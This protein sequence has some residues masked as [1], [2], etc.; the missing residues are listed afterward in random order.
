MNQRNARFFTFVFIFYFLFLL[1][2]FEDGKLQLRL[3][4]FCSPAIA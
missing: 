2:G 4:T 1:S 3:M